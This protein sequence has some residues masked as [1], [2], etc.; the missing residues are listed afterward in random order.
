M[1]IAEL[2]IRRPITTVML[3][4]S[5]VDIGLIAAVR[6][7]L[8]ALPAIS[9]P[10]VFINLPYPGSTPEEVERMVLR[11]AET[12]K[13]IARRRWVSSLRPRPVAVRRSGS[14]AISTSFCGAPSTS[15]LATPGMRSSRRL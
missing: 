7:P 14:I 3:F 4:V 11:P 13:L 9:F 6:L 12:E 5:M 8:E 2:S 1:S 15:T 10:G